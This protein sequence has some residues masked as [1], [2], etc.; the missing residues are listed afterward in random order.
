MKFSTKFA[1]RFR[2]VILIIFIF[3]FI[4]S[5]QSF[6]IEKLWVKDYYDPYDNNK[7][8]KA[9]NS[10][11]KNGWYPGGLEFDG[12]DFSMIWLNKSI[13]NKISFP[14]YF[15]IKD[16][17]IFTVQDTEDGIN[18]QIPAK[19]AG[20]YIPISLSYFG[21]DIF[22]FAILPEENYQLESFIISHWSKKEEQV[23]SSDINNLVAK[24]FFPIGFSFY[25][26][27][28]VILSIKIKGQ[29]PEKDFYWGIDWVANEAN[30][31]N[32]YY[33]YLFDKGFYPS[34]YCENSQ[35]IGVL[36]LH[37]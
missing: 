12:L 18:K 2:I 34:D 17:K 16:F 36:I 23:V 26:D 3:T 29:K 31:V 6:S 8:E 9:I 1:Y 14:I 28:Y 30:N 5:F 22:I 21:D 32:K 35:Q 24:G 19:L 15:K 13:L 20:G 11:I 7:T 4:F 27:Y 10:R 25:L 37:R 33:Q